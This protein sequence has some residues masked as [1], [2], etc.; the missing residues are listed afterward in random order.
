MIGSKLLLLYVYWRKFWFYSSWTR[1]SP[2]I[3]TRGRCNRAEKGGTSEQNQWAK[4]RSLN[5]W[6]NKSW[7]RRTKPYRNWETCGP[8]KVFSQN[9]I[10]SNANL[11]LQPLAQ[12]G[13]IE[14]VSWTTKNT[15]PQE[16]IMPLHKRI[17]GK[18]RAGID[19]ART[20]W[21]SWVWG[22]GIDKGE[23]SR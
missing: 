23:A 7:L 17:R 12:R 2:L 15:H 21:V 13:K 18:L 1:T 19:P 11:P 20:D 5:L 14:R 10:T 8:T 4:I 3:S 22:V 6:E 16:S 9:I